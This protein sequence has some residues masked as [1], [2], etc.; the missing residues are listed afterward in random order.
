[1][2]VFLT[3]VVLYR[4]RW[5][6][7]THSSL[8]NNLVT[9][10]ADYAY[11]HDTFRKNNYTTGKFVTHD[12]GYTPIDYKVKQ[13]VLWNYRSVCSRDTFVILLYFIGT[14]DIL[15]RNL[16]RQYLRQ[17]MVADGKRINYMFVVVSEEDDI[18][19][20][21]RLMKENDLFGDLPL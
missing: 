10:R 7:S 12:S 15:R 16:I 11:V 5:G 4:M 9:R 6:V 21:E 19:T 3:A 17:D 8:C 13:N 18:V 1:M 14:K 20:T 2:F